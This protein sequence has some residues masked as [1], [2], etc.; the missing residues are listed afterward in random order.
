MREDSESVGS[1]QRGALV[2]GGF[3]IYVFPLCDCDTLGSV[4]NVRI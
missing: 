4:L 3:A 1:S 2:E